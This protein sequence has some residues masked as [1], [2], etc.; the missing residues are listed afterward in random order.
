M[1]AGGA[2]PGAGRPPG[3]RNRL[4]A[5]VRERVDEMSRKHGVDLIEGLVMLCRKTEDAETR[6]KASV[7]LL[8]YVYPKLSNV[9]V[10]ADPDSKGPVFGLIIDRGPARGR[11]FE[12]VKDA[13]PVPTNGQDIDPLG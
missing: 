5:E 10:S 12:Q 9:Q 7:A 1:P 6:I 11:V 2:Q 8:P 3:T 4:S 13:L